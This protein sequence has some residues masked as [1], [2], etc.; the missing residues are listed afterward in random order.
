MAL[1]R[2]NP[3][4]I[5][6]SK[7]HLMNSS[8]V[9]PSQHQAYNVCVEFA[10]RWIL[11]KFPDKFFNSVFV[12]GK[13]GYDEFRKYS[14]IDQQVRRK[15]PL[16]AIEPNID[17]E[18]NRDWIDSRPEMPWLL[19]RSP[20]Q[21]SFFRDICRNIYLQLDF[22][23]ILMTFNYKFRVNTKAEQLDMIDFLKLKCRC[24]YTESKYMTLDIHVP[25][26]V[27]LQIAHD[28]GFEIDSSYN[29]VQSA[30]FLDYLNRNSLIPFVNKRRNT[31]GNN[32]YFIRVPECCVHL[33]INNPS[34]DDGEKNDMTTTNY[35]IEMQ[36]EIE[37]LAPYLYSYY[38]KADFTYIY[39]PKP[40][41]EADAAMIIEE[42]RLTTPPAKD[43]H[44][45]DLLVSTEYMV[46]QSDL[47][48]PID[49]DFAE[50]FDGTDLAKIIQYTKC[51]AINPATF[52]NFN[53]YNGG[54]PCCYDIDW[55]TMK[56]K[57]RN[58]I[59]NLTTVICIY[60]DKQYVANTK[61]LI[62]S[63]DYKSRLSQIHN[64]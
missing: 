55:T 24:G 18:H 33:K 62:E 58:P 12:S 64:D 40:I 63:E 50:L 61:A 7:V 27:I 29:V 39:D 51:I 36:A 11:E 54:K 32:E 19:R 42:V 46:E 14:E 17:L 1:V 16:I 41:P 28:A 6:K 48:G 56:C 25:R 5:I 45:W 59:F 21:Q 20:A 60:V 44:C 47:F 15:N 9:L 35:I 52:I 57:I 3:E 37:M 53:I 22:K 13:H 10:K 26:Q 2:V 31:T 30:K 34:G 23:T 38:S 43:E 4:D 8:I 49:I